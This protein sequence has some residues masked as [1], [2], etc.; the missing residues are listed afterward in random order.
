MAG[1]KG[2][3]RAR[4]GAAR[5]GTRGSGAL[6]LNGAVSRGDQRSRRQIDDGQ[7]HDRLERPARAEGISRSA[8]ARGPGRPDVGGSV[9]RARGCERRGCAARGISCRSGFESRSFRDSRRAPKARQHRIAARACGSRRNIVGPGGKFLARS[10]AAVCGG[11]PRGVGHSRAPTAH[12]RR[13][14]RRDRHHPR[15][16]RRAHRLVGPRQPRDRGAV[17][18]ARH[19]ARDREP[20]ARSTQSLLRDHGDLPRARPGRRH[21]CADRRRQYGHARD[22]R[23]SF[24]RCREPAGELGRARAGA[25]GRLCRR[26]GRDE[27]LRPNPQHH[28][29]Q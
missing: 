22:A 1:R 28:Q 20:G 23:G 27:L 25:R 8:A 9:W 15:C 5:C 3:S 17:Q 7:G 6:Q 11:A 19:Y 24:A 29:S 18:L 10:A 4:R 26:R 2:R 12:A 16:D 21:R 14:R 13:H